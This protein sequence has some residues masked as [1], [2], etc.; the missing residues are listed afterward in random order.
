MFVRRGRASA[1]GTIRGVVRQCVAVHYP[2]GG[3][4]WVGPRGPTADEKGLAASFDRHRNTLLSHLAGI[5]EAIP[6]DV[7]QRGAAITT[8]LTAD[9]APAVAGQ[10][11]RQVLSAILA[12]GL[13]G[14][15]VRSPAA[16]VALAV[17]TRV[18][19]ADPAW[20]ST[21][22]RFSRGPGRRPARSEAPVP[23]IGQPADFHMGE[24]RRNLLLALSKAGQ[25][26]KGKQLAA[27]AGYA[28][29]YARQHL[30][31][32]RRA[33]YLTWT[34]D[35]YELTGIGRDFVSANIVDKITVTS[36]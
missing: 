17:D 36:H 31:P 28:S 29:A 4:A 6:W 21:A 10:W 20:A 3:P 18:D 30:A 33:G 15:G 19:P 32:L 2:P 34:D 26:V 35:G 8:L 9:P 23:A 12:D 5:G 16:G 24:A 13:H 1:E 11:L 22:L 25:P 27:L 7:R 14:V